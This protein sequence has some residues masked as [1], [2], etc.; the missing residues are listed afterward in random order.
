MQLLYN[1]ARIGD[2][3]GALNFNYFQG[4]PSGPISSLTPPLMVANA[5]LGFSTR[6]GKNRL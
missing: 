1:F 2:I 6:V 3:I 5:V 4:I